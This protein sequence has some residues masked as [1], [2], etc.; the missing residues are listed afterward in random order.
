LHF[1]VS[2]STAEEIEICGE[3][4]PD[5]PLWKGFMIREVFRKVRL[6][7]EDRM[8]LADGIWIGIRN[9]KGQGGFGRLQLK[10]VESGEDKK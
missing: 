4:F 3:A 2:A 9:N 10:L 6:R 5:V 7:A 1:S 8:L